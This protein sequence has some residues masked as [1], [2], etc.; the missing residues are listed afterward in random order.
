M[1]SAVTRTDRVVIIGGGIAALS[2]A[3]AMAPRP[4]L[5]IAPEPLGHGASSAWAQGGVAAAVGPGDRPADHLADT[6]RAG[7]GLVDEAVAARVTA[8]AAE[9]VARLSA[10]GAPFDR[11]LHG[12][13]LLSREAAHGMARV[14]RVGGD[15][16]GRAIMQTLFGALAKAAHVRVE[17][18]I[19]AVG[20]RVEGGRVVGLAIERADGLGCGEILAPAV[21]MAGGGAAGLYAVTT[22]PNRI[23]GQMLGMAARAGA[24]LRDAEF[25]QFHPT[26]IDIGE[27]PAPL[28]TEA[29]RGEGACLINDRGA[30]FMLALAPEAELAPR[31]VVAR[32][33]FAEWQ[34]GRRPMLDLR[35]LGDRIA[36]H[37]PTVD[38]A[39]RRAVIDPRLQP[40]PVTAAAHYHMGG[41][42]VDVAGR[43]SLPGLWVAGEAA[44]TG[45][46]GANRL[47]SN[48]LLEALVMGHAAGL[49]IA[50]TLSGTAAED[51]EIR[52]AG[53]APV[54][55]AAKV[56]ELR[57]VMTADVG[58][59][60]HATGLTRALD[61]IAALE[62]DAPP[63]FAN[64]LAA[65]HVIT[66]AAL[67]RRESRGAHCRTDFPGSLP[68]RPSLLT[69]ADAQSLKEPA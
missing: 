42:A 4:V 20:L 48:G 38:T 52:V 63:A 9:H 57:R 35:G 22:N 46:H 56:A 54:V 13:Y 47:A 27:D 16:A 49:D 2:A 39:C 3:L 18:G 58:V 50:A 19:S 29:L 67:W 14:V 37:F 33:V 8:E 43:S 6:I 51:G 59:L 66:T 12:N 65:A 28:A 21:L 62:P 45:L 36:D 24:L 32:G 34:A 31:D 53:A 23:R 61:V 26:A 7:A 25:V 17:T 44:C 30:R 15:R 40:V 11:D 69:L 55:D 10:L 64:M 41:V 1:A 5:L 60:R 68:P